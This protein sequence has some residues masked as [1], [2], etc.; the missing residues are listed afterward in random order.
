MPLR[1]F[2]VRANRF[3][4]SRTNLTSKL[5]LKFGKGPKA[6]H[7]GC[8]QSVRIDERNEFNEIEKDSGCNVAG[9]LRNVECKWG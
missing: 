4:L 1:V 6:S 8:G 3:A 5:P 2:R 7:V 9:E